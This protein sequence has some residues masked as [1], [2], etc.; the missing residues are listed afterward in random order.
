M[1]SMARWSAS[2]RNDTLVVVTLR[3]RRAAGLPSKV[4]EDVPRK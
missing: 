3:L 1:K 2:A 4:G